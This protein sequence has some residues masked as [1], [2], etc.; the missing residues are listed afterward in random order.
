MAISELFNIQDE[1]KSDIVQNSEEDGIEKNGVKKRILLVED[2]PINQKIA[3][4]MLLRLN[5][6]VV[7]APNGQE[8]LNILSEGKDKFNL[9]LMDVQMPVLNGLD[10]TK[11]LR[12]KGVFLPVIAMTANVLKGDR[13]IC[14]E[15][16]MND[17][18]GKPVRI[19]TLETTLSRWLKTS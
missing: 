19:E 11:E 13:E 4:K 7:I 18:I 3:E 10:A 12:A 6:E 17:Y 15:A 14:L 2:N 8:A 16:G 9:I 1:K 5:Y